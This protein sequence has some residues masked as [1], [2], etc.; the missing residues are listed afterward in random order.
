MNLADVFSALSMVAA[1][2]AW[3]FLILGAFRRSSETL[4]RSHGYWALANWL[5]FVAGVIN[6]NRWLAILSGL[7]AVWMT[8]LWW[9]N[10]RNRR[11]R[12]ALRELGAKSRARIAAMVRNMSPSPIASP[13]GA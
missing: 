12:R 10:R 13:A 11:R 9:N 6:A 3:Y 1:A 7:C 4:E 8:W 5:N 2:P